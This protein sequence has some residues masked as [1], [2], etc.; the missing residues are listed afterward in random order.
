MF[1]AMKKFQVG[2]IE[3]YNG[4]EIYEE[5]IMDTM[6]FVVDYCG[7]MVL[8]DDVQSARAFIEINF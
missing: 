4:V 8:F 7:D 3:Y 1:D 6:Y 2:T 5:K